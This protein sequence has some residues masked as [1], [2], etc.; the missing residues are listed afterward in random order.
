VG[1]YYRYFRRVVLTEKAFLAILHG[2]IFFDRASSAAGRLV[3]PFR[4]SLSHYFTE[5][6]LS[7]SCRL[8]DDDVAVNDM[9]AEIDISDTSYEVID[10]DTEKDA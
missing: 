1:N 6:H 10:E 8:H 3:T 4:T 2:S 7:L 9:N 5:A